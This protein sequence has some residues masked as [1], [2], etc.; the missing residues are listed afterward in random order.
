MDSTPSGRMTTLWTIGHSNHPLD[1]FLDLLAQHRIEVLVD[2]RSSPY[3][4]YADHFNREAIRPALHSRSIQYL[5]LGDLLGGRVEDQRYYD[6]DG[7]VLYGLLAE[8]PGFCQGIERLSKGIEQFRVAILCGEENPA[9]CHRRLLVGRVMQEHGVS[10]MHI[11]ADGSVQSE[12]ELAVEEAFRKTKG[13]KTLFE[14]EEPDEWKSIQS[15]S[16]R[17]TPPS[18]LRLYDESESGD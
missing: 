11:R 15:V 5:Y 18:S 2:V 4:R 3:S 17:K 8:S 14:T 13:Q 10:L 1:A 7:R 9:N 6:G 12:A 16:P